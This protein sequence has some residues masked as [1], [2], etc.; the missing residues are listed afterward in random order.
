MKIDVDYCYLSD[1][2]GEEFN[3]N[4]YR[5]IPKPGT[6]SIQYTN[7]ISLFKICLSEN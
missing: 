6:V 5:S 2:I 1:A 3:P 4:S 7:A